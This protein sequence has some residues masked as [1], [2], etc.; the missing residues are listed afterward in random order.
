MVSVDIWE[1]NAGDLE[2]S[3]GKVEK[4]WHA[5]QGPYRDWATLSITPSI[6]TTH[7]SPAAN[8]CTGWH[9]FVTNGEAT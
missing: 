9:G 8:G 4:L 5:E 3:P 1:G 2:I 6:D 7:N